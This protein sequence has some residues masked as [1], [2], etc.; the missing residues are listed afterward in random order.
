MSKKNF[1]KH[2]NLFGHLIVRKFNLKKKYYHDGHHVHARHDGHVHVR[3][4]D[5]VRVRGVAFC[6]DEI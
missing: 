4:R 3:P 5:R 6:N 2:Q 1:F